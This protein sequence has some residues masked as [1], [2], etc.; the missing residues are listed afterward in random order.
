MVVIMFCSSAEM[1]PSYN[2]TLVGWM[3]LANSGLV[4]Q[5]IHS[6]KFWE[7]VPSLDA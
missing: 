3:L 7:T 4:N 2:L 5:L 6:E 1:Y